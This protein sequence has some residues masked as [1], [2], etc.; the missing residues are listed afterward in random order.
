MLQSF[1]GNYDQDKTEGI[2]FADYLELVDWTGRAQRTDKRGSILKGTPPIQQR[3]GLDAET[4]IAA[5]QKPNLSRGTVIGNIAS[6]KCY[7]QSNARSRGD[8]TCASSDGLDRNELPS[9]V[10]PILFP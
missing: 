5:I 2:S 10:H 9:S 8:G 3:L 1:A 7:A 6:R 4:F